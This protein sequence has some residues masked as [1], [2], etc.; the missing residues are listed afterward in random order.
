MTPCGVSRCSGQRDQIE[1]ATMV[2]SRV[3]PKIGT[4]ALVNRLNCNK[5]TLMA[6]ATDHPAYPMQ[7]MSD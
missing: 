2:F 5:M 6:R 3:G 7:V 4:W 1:H